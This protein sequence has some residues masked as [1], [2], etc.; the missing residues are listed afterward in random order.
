MTDE[1]EKQFIK[2]VISISVKEI[3]G[4][5]TKDIAKESFTPEII[6]ITAI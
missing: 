2:D 5:L 1:P 3:K 4:I 6:N